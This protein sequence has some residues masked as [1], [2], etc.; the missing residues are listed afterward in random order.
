MFSPHLQAR[1]TEFDTQIAKFKEQTAPV[2]LLRERNSLLPVSQLPPELVIAILKPTIDTAVVL[3]DH[4]FSTYPQNSVTCRRRNLIKF[5]HIYSHWRDIALAC[6]ALWTFICMSNVE[7]F[8]TLLDRSEDYP[9]YVDTWHCV[10][11][12]DYGHMFRRLAANTHRIHSLRTHPTP[13]KSPIEGGHDFEVPDG[14]GDTESRDYEGLSVAIWCRDL[15]SYLPA[16]T[17]LVLECSDPKDEV[18][19]LRRC[20]AIRRL[21]IKNCSGLK[22]AVESLTLPSLSYLQLHSVDWPL[23]FHL[24]LPHYDTWTSG[25]VST[26]AMCYLSSAI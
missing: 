1:I 24:N 18:D 16:L 19:I 7:R 12:V 5:T 2:D 26:N 6:P 10:S 22:N 3:R 11:P 15:P 13:T 14:V 20:P 23:F 21:L 9:L 8:N 17:I 4:A 25:N